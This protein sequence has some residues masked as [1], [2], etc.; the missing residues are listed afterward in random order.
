MGKQRGKIVAGAVIASLSLGGTLLM[1]QA[2]PATAAPSCTADPGYVDATG[3]Q[4]VQ[5]QCNA[6]WGTAET[7]TVAGNPDP[8]AASGYVIADGPASNP[9]GA[10]GYYG[11]DNQG[12][13]A[14]ASGDYTPGTAQ[15]TPADDG[16]APQAPT[17]GL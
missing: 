1:A 15:R 9:E 13:V 3:N 6:G 12:P 10:D 11:V 16:C 7:V 8:S 4:G 5:G 17:L 14:C 2:G